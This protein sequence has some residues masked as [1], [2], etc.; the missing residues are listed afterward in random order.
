[1]IIVVAGDSA[2]E[3][4][5]SASRIWDTA[6]RALPRI[7]V[8]TI[9]IVAGWGLGR[10]VRLGATAIF[11]RRHTPS[12]ATVMGKLTGWMVATLGVL[13]ALAVTF[14]SVQP[15]D[16]LAGLGFFS[17]AIGF[18]FQDILENLLAG[19]LLLFRQPFV[20]GDQIRVGDN[21]GTVE[22]IT[23]RETVLL[24]FDGQRILIPN[25]DVYKS[26]VRIY[27]ARPSRRT[28][29]LV[30]IAYEA[31]LDRARGAARD[32]LEQVPG[33]LGDPPPEA[34]VV[35]LKG[36][37]VDLDVR[38]WSS[39]RELQRRA[40]LDRAIAAVKRAFDDAGI[41]MPSDIVALQAT[42]SFEAALR[43]HPVT[44]G[45]AVAPGDGDPQRRGTRR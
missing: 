28:S 9:V 5:E 30:G 20:G 36:S 33:V 24:T 44:P 39:A 10:L 32:A 16:L 37:T 41:E 21:E 3:I 7:G 15:V 31:D 34:L 18:A 40:V 4:A 26:A 38:F 11:G 25:A 19:I 13:L 23:I 42:S 8:A 43:G 22:R 14:P 17:V 35:E 12:F 27:T 2:D 6:V 1:V 45:G 29:F